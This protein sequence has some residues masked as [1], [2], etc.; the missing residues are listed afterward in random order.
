[1]VLNANTQHE[2]GTHTFSHIV[3]DDPDCTREIFRSQLKACVDLHKRY[4]LD[5]KS[6]VYPRNSI[7][8]LD[9]LEECE[10][11]AYRGVERRWYSD[12]DPR[13][14][15]IL[16]VLDRSLALTPRTYS[17]VGL[18]KNH[19]VNIP[20]SMFFM[21]CDGWRGLIPI[22]SRVRQAKRGLR[23]A[24][25]RGE[26]FHLWFHPFNLAS[27]PRLFVGIEEV[28]ELARE[29]RSGRELSIVTMRDAAELVRQQASL[30][31]GDLS[32]G[33]AA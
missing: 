13:L 25:R 24:A 18:T 5:L 14:V 22:A 8:F 9:V 1:M 2:I 31:M 27:D 29:L 28:L 10:I 7:A 4:K 32:N 17:L 12:L 11:T 26:L 20:A 21:P 23:R 6:I 15:S 3:V 19:L 33:G 16:R 30:T